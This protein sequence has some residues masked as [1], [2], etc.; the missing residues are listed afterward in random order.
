MNEARAAL[1]QCLEVGMQNGYDLGWW[2]GFAAGVIVVLVSGLII[3]AVRHH[4]KG[5][6]Q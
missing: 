2:Q 3:S 6:Y 5:N 1:A 4:I